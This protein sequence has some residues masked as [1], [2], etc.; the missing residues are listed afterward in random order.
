MYTN[1]KPSTYPFF[2]F[3][4]NSYS[5]FWKAKVKTLVNT[6]TIQWIHSMTKYHEPKVTPTKKKKNK[7]KNKIHV[8]FVSEIPQV[9]K[10]GKRSPRSPSH[11]EET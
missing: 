4:S 1:T 5:S 7:K 8:H 10:Q 6:A 11:I 3:P 9:A 2:I